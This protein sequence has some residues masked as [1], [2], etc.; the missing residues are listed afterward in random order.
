MLC[1]SGVCHCSR[2]VIGGA[3]HAI[4]HSLEASPR[5]VGTSLAHLSVWKLYPGEILGPG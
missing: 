1:S 2:L 5:C 3:M 4:H